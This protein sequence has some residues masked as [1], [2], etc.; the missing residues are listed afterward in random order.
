MSHQKRTIGC[1]N[2]LLLDLFRDHLQGASRPNL[3][4]AV[5][6]A[7]PPSKHRGIRAHTGVGLH[8]P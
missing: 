4:K 6:F 2:Q 1:V 5:S 7:V 3:R 8:Q